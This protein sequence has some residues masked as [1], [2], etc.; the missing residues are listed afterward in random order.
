[1][2]LPVAFHGH[3]TST[4]STPMEIGMKI[5]SSGLG[6]HKTDDRCSSATLHTRGKHLRRVS[7]YQRGSHLTEEKILCRKFKYCMTLKSK[8][9]RRT[10]SFDTNFLDQSL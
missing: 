4:N 6:L 3:T 7:G 10:I 2:T 1:M 8:T 9:Q 5:F